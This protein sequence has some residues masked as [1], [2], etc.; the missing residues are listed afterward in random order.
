M[1]ITS[2]VIDSFIRT[3]LGSQ[4]NDPEMMGYIDKILKSQATVSPE[5]FEVKLNKLGP[6]GRRTI[7][8]GAQAVLKDEHLEPDYRARLTALEQRLANWGGQG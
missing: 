3:E 2:N 4:A 6:I 8:I 7:R 5:E 1:K